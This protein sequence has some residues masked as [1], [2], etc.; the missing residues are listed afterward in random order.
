MNEAQLG[1]RLVLAKEQILKEYDDTVSVSSKAKVLKKFGRFDTLGTTEL[2]IWLQ[3]QDETYVSDNSID[4]ISSSNA[5]DDQDIV[6]EGHTLTNGV[7]VFVSQTATLNGQT[8]VVLDTPLHRASRVYNDDNT[9]FAG[10]VYVY[11]DGAITAGV[12]DTASTIHVTA[13]EGDNQSLKCETSISD[14]DYLILTQILVSVNRQQT[15]NV[16]FRLKVRK[17]GKVFRTIYPI[18]S[19][20]SGV[21]SVPI[22]L[23]PC[24]IVPPN[25][26]ILMSGVS[27]GANTGAGAMFAGYFAEKVT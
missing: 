20:A 7:L 23:D 11:E 26:D 1:H 9:D 21:G 4:T 5:G 10:T 8:K 18:I 19:C 2:P 3:G 13:V 15:R 25:A 27:S 24:V 14:S 12:P 17:Q 16:D 6:V 22:T